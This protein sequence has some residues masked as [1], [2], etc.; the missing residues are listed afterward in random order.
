MIQKK[1]KAQKVYLLKIQNL[2][3]LTRYLKCWYFV[4]FSLT[5][6]IF[7]LDIKIYFIGIY[8]FRPINFFIIKIDLYS[9]KVTNKIIFP[10]CE[11]LQ[12]K[13]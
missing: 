12:R 10:N 7:N 5:F 2:S 11:Q 4:Y 13:L 9:K 6:Q 1:R 8:H 3:S